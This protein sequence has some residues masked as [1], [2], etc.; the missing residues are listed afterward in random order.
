MSNELLI[1][2]L[3]ILYECI[4]L[5]YLMD[6]IFSNTYNAMIA[7][8]AMIEYKAMDCKLSNIYKMQ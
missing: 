3:L 1:L 8:N 2:I 4:L 5:I 6:R 7:C